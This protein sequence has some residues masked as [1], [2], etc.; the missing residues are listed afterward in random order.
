M[1]DKKLKKRLKKIP[2]T[3]ENGEP[4]YKIDG[5]DNGKQDRKSNKE[6][7]KDEFII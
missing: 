7:G 3:D 2:D 5:G 4:I 6:G 1:E